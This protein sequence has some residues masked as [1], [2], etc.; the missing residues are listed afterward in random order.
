MRESTAPYL[1]QRFRELGE[2]PL[3]GEVRGVGMFGALELVADK[4]NFVKFDKDLKVGDICRD[5]CFDNNLVMRAVGDAM[6][7]SPPLILQPADVDRF[8]ER[9]W[10]CLD[11]TREA[12]A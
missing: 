3:V 7:I 12:I 10:K 1:Q 2:H 8:I 9:A 11:L 5:L 4:E 6:I